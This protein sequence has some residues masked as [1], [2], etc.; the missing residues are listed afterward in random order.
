[1]VD[2][3]PPETLLDYLLFVQQ[4]PPGTCAVSSKASLMHPTN[5]LHVAGPCH[6]VRSCGEWFYAPCVRLRRSH[7]VRY[8][9]VGTPDGPCMDYGMTHLNRR[10][11]MIYG[12][13][14]RRLHFILYASHTTHTHTRTRTTKTHSCVC[15]G[16]QRMA[17]RYIISLHYIILF[18]FIEYMC[19]H[20]WQ[21]MEYRCMHRTHILQTQAWEYSVKRRV[22]SKGT[23]SSLPNH[24]NRLHL[25][26]VYG[27]VQ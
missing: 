15:T 10:H 8:L 6:C 1:M 5:H 11:G 12:W 20:H 3:E 17:L 7:H 2:G 16:Q 19:I 26:A 22:I 23:Q 9:L 25:I 27:H 21:C 13:S 14:A 4:W 18:C 24:I